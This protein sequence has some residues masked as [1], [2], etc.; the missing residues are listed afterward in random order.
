MPRLRKSVVFETAFAR[1]S[2]T[3]IIGEG[4]SGRIYSVHD[5]DD[6]L[7]AVKALKPEKASREKVKR[8]KNEILFCS[9]NKHPNVLTT[10]DRGVAG[11]GNSSAPFY[12]M[13]LFDGSLR[14]LIESGLGADEALRFF[15]QI[16]D[17][18]E[19]AHLQGVIHRDLKPE[20]ILLDKSNS[21]LV[22][23]DFGIAWFQE[24][25]LYTAVETKDTARLAN[26]VYSAPEQRTRGC[27]YGCGTDIYALG[28]ILNEMITG[29]VPQGTDHRLIGDMDPDHRFLDELVLEMRRQSL[30]DR[31][32]TIEAV[33]QSLIGHKKR[34]V[35]QQ[36]LSELREMVVPVTDVDDPIIADPIRLID[37]DW[38]P[39]VLTLKLSQPVNE[40]WIWALQNMRSYGS[41]AGHE[42]GRF[43]L[44]QNKATIR[45]KERV[46]QQ[47][48]NN[49]KA[50]LPKANRVYEER[51][52]REKKD[53]EERKRKELEARVKAQ[54]AKER[55]LKN[56]QL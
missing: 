29:Q 39:E 15:A 9:R 42:P 55:V 10:V 23:A 54:Q 31:V 50:W 46:V 25:E 30:E 24:D 26:F 7:W 3:E 1:Y 40:K 51:I 4:G 20:N 32:Q 6:N 14:N 11:S 13:H 56:V 19:A 34:F 35:T 45:A 52:Q 16:L 38:E 8:F 18:V 44:K 41:L 21:V 28:L 37:F 49:F 22:V 17:G 43:S 53:D 33:K 27:S 12:V 36:R 5:E 2:A 47:V 48:I